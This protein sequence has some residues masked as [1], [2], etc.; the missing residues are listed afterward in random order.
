MNDRYDVHLADAQAT[1]SLGERI[2]ALLR[3][4]DLVVLSG[5][6]GA[7]KTT[8]AKGIGRGLDVRGPITSPTFVVARRHPSLVSGPD[9][10]HVDAYRLRSRAEL[11]DVWLDHQG[12]VMVVEWGRGLVDDM[13]ASRLE[14]DLE[15]AGDGRIARIAVHG[16]RW[17]A[18]DLS[19]LG[20]GGD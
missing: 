12:A 18:V 5:E 11:D 9:L 15:H 7:G 2:A 17:E 13:T 8:L 6:L 16:E 14:I 1:E 19:A 20:S 10:L 3:A 4:G